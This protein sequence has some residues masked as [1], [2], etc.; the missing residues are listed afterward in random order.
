MTI[1]NQHGFTYLWL[2][3]MVVLLIGGAF[4]IKVSNSSTP[5]PSKINNLNSSVNLPN[6]IYYT[7]V[8][9]WQAGDQVVHVYSY[10]PY[11]KNSKELFSIPTSKTVN[12]SRISMSPDKTK[13]VYS[14]YQDTPEKTRQLFSIDSN[15]SNQKLILSESRPN[16]HI[17]DNLIWSPDS[18]ELL[19]DKQEYFPYNVYKY[20]F[21]TG[22]IITIN[23]GNIAPLTGWFTNNKLGFKQS[24]PTGCTAEQECYPAFKLFQTDLDGKN[25]KQVFDQVDNDIGVSYDWL[26]DGSG[27]ILSGSSIKSVLPSHY[28][29]SLK[30]AQQIKTNTDTGIIQGILFHEDISLMLVREGSQSVIY[31]VNLA[32]NEPTVIKSFNESIWLD[33]ISKDGKYFLIHYGNTDQ[34]IAIQKNPEIY[35]MQGNLVDQL[36]FYPNNIEFLGFSQ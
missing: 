30:T 32:N 1:R 21:E 15:G 28:D 22:K 16:G 18:K 25:L 33:A 14:I 5:L 35:D 3:L 11:T 12:L 27:V 7:H 31:K 19:F 26:P 6:I 20:S 36:P 2:I 29:F 9:S 23:P 34:G 13:I 17:F 4:Y 10:N 24:K 8:L